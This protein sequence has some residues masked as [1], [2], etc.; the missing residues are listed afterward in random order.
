MG[1]VD[2]C[3]MMGW[4]VVSDI[5]MDITVVPGIVCEWYYFLVIVMGSVVGPAI[6][7]S[8]TDF[9]DIVVVVVGVRT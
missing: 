4:T 9:S 2:C 7:L 3:I 1:A 5:M 6:V 8:G